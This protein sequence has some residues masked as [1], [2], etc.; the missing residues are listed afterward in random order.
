MGSTIVHN[1]HNI[2]IIETKDEFNIE[3]LSFL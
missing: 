2:T 1:S 3:V